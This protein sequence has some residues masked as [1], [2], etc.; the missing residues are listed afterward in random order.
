M[1]LLAVI[2]ALELLKREGLTIQIFSDSKYVVEAV[3][4]KWLF[5]WERKN[6]KDKKNPDLWKR[7]LALYRRHSIQFVWVKGH[8]DNPLNNRCDELATQA[9]DSNNLL[10][11]E[12]YEN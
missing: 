6:F 1:E 7:F 10:I 12:G 11:D 5:G 2:A 3:E 4:K 9:A 8:A